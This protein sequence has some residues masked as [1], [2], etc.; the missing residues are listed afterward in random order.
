MNGGIIRA[1]RGVTLPA[2]PLLWAM[3]VKHAPRFFANSITIILILKT[4]KI[5]FTIRKSFR[6]TILTYWSSLY[7]TKISLETIS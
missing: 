4:T 6:Q 7:P 3:Q 1:T 2:W 5:Q